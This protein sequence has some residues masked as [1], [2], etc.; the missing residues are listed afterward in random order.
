M[1]N[2]LLLALCVENAFVYRLALSPY[3]SGAFAVLFEAIIDWIQ[4]FNNFRVTFLFMALHDLPLC[5]TN[6][7][8]I[9]A[10]RCSGP[11]VWHWSFLVSNI[12]TTVS[13]IWRLI[14]L[15]YSYDRLI[16]TIRRR[17]DQN[18]DTIKYR[19][20]LK[21]FLRD[22]SRL[23]EHDEAWPIRWAILIVYGKTSEIPTTYMVTT[24]ESVGSAFAIALSA[25]LLKLRQILGGMIRFVCVVL[26]TAVAYLGYMV[27]CCIPC[28]HF[29]TMK[30]NSFAQRHKC[31]KAFVRYFTYIYHFT[32]L[33]FSLICALSLIGLNLILL[34]SVHLLGSNSVPPEL[35]KLCMSVNNT[36]FTIKPMFVDSNSYNEPQTNNGLTTCKPIW[37]ET[38]FG[39]K[40]K[41][42]DAGPWQARIRF[43]NSLLVIASH[44]IPNYE[45]RQKPHHTLIYDYGII[46]RRD[47]EYDCV[48]PEMTPWRF[49][50]DLFLPK[51][52]YFLACNPSF[53]I[54]RQNLIKCRKGIITSDGVIR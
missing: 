14:M 32:I 27:V 6:F 16:T 48:P 29:Y 18:K 52:P 8:L 13:L 28:I 19:R 40:V 25:T 42:L 26:L 43:N 10:C 12:T 15:Y 44:L 46:V 41:R 24:P 1:L 54:Q 36:D 2:G 33:I 35:N 53:S 51:F 21:F 3:P 20:F 9:S 39:F 17:Y 37:D 45:D 34:T 7:F 23:N 5:V 38:G 11:A 30:P 47:K 50:E 31:S 4:G 49:I 22:G